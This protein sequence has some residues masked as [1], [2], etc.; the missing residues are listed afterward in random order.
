MPTKDLMLRRQQQRERMARWRA[1]NPARALAQ[2]LASNRKSRA[3][4]PERYRIYAREYRLAHLTSCPSC[5]QPKGATAKFCRHCQKGPRSSRWKGGTCLD[6]GGYRLVRAEGHPR[7]SSKGRYVREH[8]LVMEKRLGR[9]LYPNERVHHKNGKRDDNRSA[10]LELWIVSQPA[11]QRV[12]DIL[13]WAK[14]IV[15]LY[16][17]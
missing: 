5:G 7:A 6:R 16:G 15:A 10:N 2:A 4:D 3:A 9:Y 1:R 11:G 17:G 14:E 8:I 12:V 13:A